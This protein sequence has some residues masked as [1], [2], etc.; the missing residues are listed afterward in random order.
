MLMTPGSLP[1]TVV[2]V[3]PGRNFFSNSMTFTV[4]GGT[5]TGPTLA[6][7]KMH[8]GNFTQ[9]QIGATYTITTSNTGSGPTDGTQ[10]TVTDQI[11][12][13]LTITNM[14]GTGWGCTAPPACLRNDVLAAGSSYPPLTVTVD[15]ATNAP[16]T[17]TNMATGTGGGFGGVA[18]A[19]D[20]TTING[21][22]APQLA[23]S[24][25]SS[26]STFAPNG[27][28]SYM[29]TISNTGNAPT[30]GTVSL[31]VA[32]SSGLTP[33]SLLGAGW[34]CNTSMLTCT[35][36]TPLPAGMS[37]NVVT[38]DVVISSSPPPTV[39]TS[40][41]ASGGGSSPVTTSVSNPT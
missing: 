11:P 22:A 37:Y 38:F 31:V 36:A 15:V 29:V 16:A 20:P 12:S 34:S 14:S 26:P 25:N 41:T 13:G 3:T 33:A 27:T 32:P 6:L 8:T 4:T 40:F 18:T 35:I 30:T 17:L 21:P 2:N 23:I 5:P 7:S 28:G 19:S 39:M 9:G 24:A 1:I 10:V